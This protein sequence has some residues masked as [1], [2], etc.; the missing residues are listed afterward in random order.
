MLGSIIIVLLF[1]A[2]KSRRNLASLGLSILRII[3]MAHAEVS[4]LL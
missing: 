2:T 4:E 1:L 3:N